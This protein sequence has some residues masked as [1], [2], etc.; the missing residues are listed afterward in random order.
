MRINVAW[1][2]VA[3]KFNEKSQV[4]VTGEQCCHKWKK[5]EEK[6]KNVQEHNERT[7]SDRKDT[8]FQEEL[9]EFFGSN[10]KIIPLDEVAS[11]INKRFRDST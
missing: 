5:L 6:F 4:K 11:D 2:R 1:Q 9:A 3:E 7:G 10:P 8:E